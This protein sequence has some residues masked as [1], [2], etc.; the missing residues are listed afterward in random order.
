MHLAVAVRSRRSLARAACAAALLSTSAAASAACNLESPAHRVTVLELYTSEG[1]NSCP[2]ADRWLS[3]LRGHGTAQRVVPLAFH[4]DYWN[5]LGWADR[6]AQPAFSARQHEVA[7]RTASR[8]VY[9]PQVV[10]DGGDWRGWHMPGALEARLNA[11]R[12][13]AAGATIRARARLDAGAIRLGGGVALGDKSAVPSA[14]TWAAIYEHGLSS[15]VAAG[16]N[17]GRTLAHDY[18]VRALA[19][20]AVA[21]GD[22]TVRL[23][24]RIPVDETWDAGR[25]GVALFI[26]RLDSGAIL[27]AAAVEGCLLRRDARRPAPSGLRSLAG[28]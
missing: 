15:V 4:V 3:S 7:R 28:L 22:G 21:G 9:T 17:R 11:A 10:L 19:G 27:Q 24:L 6:F 26:E 8:L 12:P 23:D 20:P 2:P 25:L 13:Q 14:R 5:Y 18:V 16:E 1:C